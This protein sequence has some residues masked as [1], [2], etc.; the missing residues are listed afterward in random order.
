MR[1]RG[2]KFPSDAGVAGI[3]SRAVCA[4]GAFVVASNN[5]DGIASL[6]DGENSRRSIRAGNRRGGNAPTA[7]PVRRTEDTCSSGAACGEINLVTEGGQG[8]SACCKNSLS[9]QSCRHRVVREFTPTQAVVCVQ[10]QEFPVN[11]IADGVA[12]GLRLANQVV[13]KNRRAVG[14]VLERPVA[15]SVGCFVDARRRTGPNRHYVGDGGAEGLDG[16]EV[17]RRRVWHI[18]ARPCFASIA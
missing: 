8:S 5:H 16:A 12:L 15:T 10:E 1:S 4:I 9:G 2:G 6:S 14:G 17:E 7:S 13:K 18:E 11:G 3:S